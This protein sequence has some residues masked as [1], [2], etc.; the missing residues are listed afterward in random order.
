MLPLLPPPFEN[1]AP[2]PPAELVALLPKKV[3]FEMVM[4]PDGALRMLIP[5]PNAPA[6]LLENVD[7]LTLTTAFGTRMNTPPPLPPVE[8]L[9]S[10][11][12]ST[13]LTFQPDV[14]T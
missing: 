4:F 9:P 6:V 11:V 2:R 5:P 7:P 3:Q 14:G 13:I 12:L 8:L 1:A 10:N